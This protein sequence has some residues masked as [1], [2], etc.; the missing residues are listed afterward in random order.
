MMC[1]SLEK[2]LKLPRREQRSPNPPFEFGDLTV[3][4]RKLLPRYIGSPRVREGLLH[5]D[6]MNERSLCVILKDII[7]D[8]GF[9]A[10]ARI[11]LWEALPDARRKDPLTVLKR[12]KH[13]LQ[14][15]IDLLYATKNHPRHL[16]GVEVKYLSKLKAEV[17]P[18]TAS[19]EG[20]YA[21]LGQA[22]SLLSCGVDFAYLW[23]VFP[24]PWEK[25]QKFI[26]LY[27]AE[28]STK[29]EDTNIEYSAAYYG[30]NSAM[31]KSFRLPL[32][33]ALI[34]LT[35]SEKGLSIIPLKGEHVSPK[36]NPLLSSPASRS[37]RRLLERSIVE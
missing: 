30:F 11:N 18:K 19:D 5:Q 20:Y 1:T 10:W 25:R 23:H 15:D 14:P 28:V 24:I 36:T 12:Y 27:G 33:Y 37:V 29:F 32:G 2:R 26:D 22:L 17:I 13:P 35:V 9:K 31:I 21:G 3:P 7:R 8:L 6:K 34:G 16:V 4:T